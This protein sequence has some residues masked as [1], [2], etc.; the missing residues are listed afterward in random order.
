MAALVHLRLHISGM[1]V[2]HFS[3]MTLHDG[4][5]SY[6]PGT[7]FQHA[8]HSDHHFVNSLPTLPG[9]P[10][11]SEVVPLSLPCRRNLVDVFSYVLWK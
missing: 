6:L 2:L 9:T 5:S 8:D 3:T 11:S 10:G 1:S 4:R 7:L